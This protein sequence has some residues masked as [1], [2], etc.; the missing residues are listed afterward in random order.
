MAKSRKSNRKQKGGVWSFFKKTKKHTPLRTKKHISKKEE[1]EIYAD[2]SNWAKMELL[3]N[4]EEERHQQEKHRSPT[5]K[6]ISPTRRHI[7]PTRRHISP[8]R[9]HISPTSVWETNPHILA[10]RR[11]KRMEK[12]GK[13]EDKKGMT[14]RERE[15]ARDAY[16]GQ[17]GRL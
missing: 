15:R 4:E 13:N 8:T 1:E 6:H 5:R 9:R 2:P 12:E 10:E 7:S 3:F 17:V 11:R 16:L 14:K